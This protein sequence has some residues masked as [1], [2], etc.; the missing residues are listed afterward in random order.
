MDYKPELDK[1]LEMYLEVE[2]DVYFYCTEHNPLP[3][4]M[5]ALKLASI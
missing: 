3:Q 2:V 4:Y 5:W 1:M